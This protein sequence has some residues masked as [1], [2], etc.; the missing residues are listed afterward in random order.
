MIQPANNPKLKAL[1]EAARQATDDALHGPPH[2]R[3]GRYN[4]T[5]DDENKNN[6]VAGD[7]RKRAPGT[8]DQG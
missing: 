4:P 2:L 6:D 7:E 1:L 5:P 8:P 3:S